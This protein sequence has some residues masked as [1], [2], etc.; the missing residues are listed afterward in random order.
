M[1]TYTDLQ[2]TLNGISVMMDDKIQ[3]EEQK[4]IVAEEKYHAAPHY[5]DYSEKIKGMQEV[6]K[7]QAKEL[8]GIVTTDLPRYLYENHAKFET[9]RFISMVPA[10]STGLY[11]ET[12]M[13]KSMDGATTL[14]LLASTAPLVEQGKD[15]SFDYLDYKSVMNNANKAPHLRNNRFKT[16]KPEYKLPIIAKEFKMVDRETGVESVKYYKTVPATFVEFAA[17]GKSLIQPRLNTRL[18]GITQNEANS[19]YWKAEEAIV[20]KLQEQHP[21]AF[22]YLSE[23]QQKYKSLPRYITKETPIP[24]Q[25]AMYAKEVSQALIAIKTHMPENEAKV[26]HVSFLNKEFDFIHPDNLTDYAPEVKAKTYDIAM[27]AQNAT[28]QAT[29]IVLGK[30]IKMVVAAEKGENVEVEQKKPLV[31]EAT[32]EKIAEAA[33]AVGKVAVDV[34]ATKHPA[35]LA[36]KAAVE[37]IGVLDSKETKEAKKTR[38]RSMPKPKTKAKEKSKDVGMEM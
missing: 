26:K 14:H 5:G 32:M 27:T 30:R 22:A 31:S 15:V 8:A 3:K 13:D 34:A 10:K 37:A 29:A 21:E 7:N 11:H 16:V 36:A 18:N 17:D 1:R 6:A 12:I 33:K 9:P 20:D 28:E 19:M 25:E 35:G 4:N 38:T 24:V 2:S 23:N